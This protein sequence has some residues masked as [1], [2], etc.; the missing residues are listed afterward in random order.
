MSTL[1]WLRLYALLKRPTVRP[2]Y[3][4]DDISGFCG[5]SWGDY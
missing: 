1:D 3:R 2:F 4:H 5:G